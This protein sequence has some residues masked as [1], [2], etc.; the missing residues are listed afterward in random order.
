MTDFEFIC[1]RFLWSV[2]NHLFLVLLVQVAYE[3]ISTDHVRPFLQVFLTDLH[4]K[5]IVH[6]H[7]PLVLTIRI[8]FDLN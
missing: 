7:M 2:I 6:I 3:A 5:Q 1:F 8:C 4:K